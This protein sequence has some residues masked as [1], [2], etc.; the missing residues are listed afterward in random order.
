MQIMNSKDSCWHNR[1]A[2]PAT[3]SVSEVSACICKGIQAY[4]CWQRRIRALCTV[5]DQQIDLNSKEKTTI[6][7]HITTNK[8][9]EKAKTASENQR[10]MV[11]PSQ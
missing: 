1:A 11:Y 3:F 6:T 2:R 10:G 7:Q 4:C 5:C 8:H 9:K